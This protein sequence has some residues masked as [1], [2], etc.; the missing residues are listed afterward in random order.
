MTTHVL[1]GEIAHKKKR[2]LISR[3][4]KRAARIV[5]K[6]YGSREISVTKVI[7]D[8][9]WQSLETRRNYFLNTLLYKCIHGTAPTRLCNEIEMYFDR[10]G[11]I[12][13]DIIY[14][15]G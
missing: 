5:S 7:Q 9:K 10:H 11:L 8:L 12:F 14:I 13:P 2:E 4:Q 15:I 1:Y 3:L 6:H